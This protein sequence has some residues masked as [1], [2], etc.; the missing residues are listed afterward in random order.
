MGYL[1]ERSGYWLTGVLEWES[2]DDSGYAIL[3]FKM[4]FRW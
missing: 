2:G 1:S 4:S 3:G